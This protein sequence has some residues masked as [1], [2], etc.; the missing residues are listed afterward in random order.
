[1]SR[2]GVLHGFC[3][4]FDAHFDE[5]HSITTSPVDPARAVHWS[6]PM[7]RVQRHA[8]LPGDTITLDL[9]W[10]GLAVPAT[11]RWTVEVT[12]VAAGSAVST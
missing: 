3:V 8:V 7:L 10:T 5:E 11:W 6:V 9:G 2:E 1:M 12:R 4:F